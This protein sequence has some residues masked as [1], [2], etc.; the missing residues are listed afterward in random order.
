MQ[1]RMNHAT[2]F[3]SD[4]TTSQPSRIASSGMAPPPAKGS[5]TRGGRPAKARLI[6]SRKPCRGWYST[7]ATAPLS[8]A[9][10]PALRDDGGRLSCPQCRIPPSVSSPIFSPAWSVLSMTVPAIRNSSS[11]LVAASG[12]AGRRVARSAALLAANGWRAGQMCRVEIWPWR[13]FF[14]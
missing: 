12:G 6:S 10:E 7:S 1:R 2:G 8:S 4:A 14:S 11:C 5:S 9:A 13:T 3:K